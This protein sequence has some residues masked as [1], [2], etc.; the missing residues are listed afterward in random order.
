MRC[1]WCFVVLMVPALCAAQV[2][3]VFSLEKTTYNSGEP[4][5]LSFTL[6]N[7]G[8]QTEEVNTADPYSFCSGYTI[9][10]TRNG[11]HEPSCLQGYGG[12]CLSG[13]ISLPPGGTHTERI[14]L[15]YPNHSKGDFGA[16]V[17][18]PGDYTVDAQREISYAP[19]GDS[20]LFTAPD[21]SEA[22]E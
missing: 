16:P 8:K 3:G 7:E 12:S 4:V 6:H 15:N 2:T 21:H 22:A 9:H 5:V 13:A 10:I 14:L 11:S 17:K 1:L 18:V 19:P 20:Q